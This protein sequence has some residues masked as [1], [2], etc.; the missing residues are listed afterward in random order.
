ME[1]KRGIV[2]S[3]VSK[4][5]YGFITDDKEQIIFFHA[6]GVC[7][8]KFEDL[9]EGQPVEYLVKKTFKGDLAIGVVVV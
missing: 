7:D 1:T 9:R 3:I 6:M 4:R 8:P 5:G 2:T